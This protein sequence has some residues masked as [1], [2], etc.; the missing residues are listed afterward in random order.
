MNNKPAT[1]LGSTVLGIIASFTWSFWGS[2]WEW[3]DIWS[4]ASWRLIVWYVFGNMTLSDP[5][6]L[7]FNSLER[8]SMTVAN[9]TA[10]TWEAFFFSCQ[11]NPE[12]HLLLLLLCLDLPPTHMTPGSI[13]PSLLLTNPRTQTQAHP[14]RHTLRSTPIPFIISTRSL[15]LHI[16]WVYL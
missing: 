7:D 16:Y 4:F 10:A 5:S 15:Y 11:E 2:W 12:S 9:K 8:R 1:S 14:R 13:N 6:T 3:R